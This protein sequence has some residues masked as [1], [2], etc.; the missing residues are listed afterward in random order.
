M[1]KYSMS[2]ILLFKPWRTEVRVYTAFSRTGL[3]AL[4]LDSVFVKAIQHLH[5]RHGVLPVHGFPKT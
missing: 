1:M 2:T 3:A 4:E 5:A